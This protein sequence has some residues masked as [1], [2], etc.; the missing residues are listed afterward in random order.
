MKEFK[1]T[2]VSL[3]DMKMKNAIDVTFSES[4][5]KKIHGSGTKVG[6]WKNGERDLEY[7]MDIKKVPAAISRFFSGGHLPVQCTQRVTKTDDS[8]HHVEN[9]VHMHNFGSRFVNV[10]PKFV[11]RKEKKEVF[12]DA[13]VKVNVWLMPPFNHIT[14]A[15]ML[16]EAQKEVLKYAETVLDEL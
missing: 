3:G 2:G 6:A 7:N 4:T 11:L 5:L 13:Q 14:E 16:K 12:F 9:I 15:F 8:C 10:E 1:L